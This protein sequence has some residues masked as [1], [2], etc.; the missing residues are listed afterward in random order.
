LIAPLI[1]AA[2]GLC[3]VQA[4][5][6]GQQEQRE[7]AADVLEREVQADPGNA[8]LWLHLGFA[9]RKLDRLDRARE[10]FEKASS[11]DPGNQEAL[12]MLGLIYEKDKRTQDALRVWKQYLSVA[13]DPEKRATAENHIHHLSQ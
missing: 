7:K 2:V 13:S 10:A 3:A 8:E 9:Q 5:P 6:A 4:L 1:A 11:L 12:Y